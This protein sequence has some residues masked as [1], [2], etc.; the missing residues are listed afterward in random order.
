M[1]LKREFVAGQ[2]LAI[3]PSRIFTEISWPIE[4]K[5]RPVCHYWKCWL[6]ARSV[7]PINEFL[8]RDRPPITGVRQ[9][10]NF[11]L[12]LLDPSYGGSI[13]YQK[14][15]KWETFCQHMWFWTYKFEKLRSFRVWNGSPWLATG[16]YFGEM[17]PRGPRAFSKYVLNLKLICLI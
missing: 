15:K 16:S 7:T 13:S 2:G 14:F 1:T 3:I 11:I 6:F 9:M 8:V 10:Q 4:G 12:H 5:S 17:T